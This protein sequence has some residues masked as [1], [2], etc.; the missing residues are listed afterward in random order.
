M[1]E[2]FH[3]SPSPSTGHMHPSEMAPHELSIISERSTS[4]ISGSTINNNLMQGDPSGKRPSM[5]FQP[6]M[7]YVYTG[8]TYSDAGVYLG[9]D[10]GGV[11]AG[12][13]STS[14][15]PLRNRSSSKIEN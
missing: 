10:D 3:P 11:Y 5:D 13:L 2:H 7:Q 6:G 4:C 14:A 1:L 12:P 8:N 9:P 15:G